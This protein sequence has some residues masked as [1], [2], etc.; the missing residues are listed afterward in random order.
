MI[1]WCDDIYSQ[2]LETGLGAVSVL[3]ISFTASTQLRR[4]HVKAVLVPGA[5]WI[6]EFLINI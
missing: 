6:T 2:V 4:E 5:E 1:D 3:G